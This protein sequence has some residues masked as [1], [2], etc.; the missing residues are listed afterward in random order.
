MDIF[1]DIFMKKLH[2]L[3]FITVTFLIVSCKDTKAGV[4]QEQSQKSSAEKQNG[5]QKELT[6]FYGYRYGEKAFKLNGLNLERTSK[7]HMDL[8][9]E[10]GIKPDSVVERGADHFDEFGYRFY[11]VY[12]NGGYLGLSAAYNF[13]QDTF[14]VFGFSSK[15]SVLDMNG[16]K[17]GDNI[18][19]VK[20]EFPKFIIDE[21]VILVYLGDNAVSFDYKNN[22][23]TRIDYYTPI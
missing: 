13:E 4:D 23:V 15:G 16:I 7:N 22:V 3:L 1:N 12:Y 8:I 10:L 11:D 19:K 5:T 2:F 17:V 14:F 21:D 9:E 20:K 6:P 18:E